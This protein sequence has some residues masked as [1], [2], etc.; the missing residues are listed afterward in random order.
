M[1]VVHFQADQETQGLEELKPIWATK[2]SFRLREVGHACTHE[3][4]SRGG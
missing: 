4:K 2:V 1:L 3:G